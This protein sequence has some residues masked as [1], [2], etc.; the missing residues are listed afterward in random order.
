MQLLFKQWQIVFNLSIHISESNETF[1]SITVVQPVD[2][3]GGGGG[4]GYD[5][6][7]HKHIHWAHW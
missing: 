7:M 2:M 1:V 6:R 3:R 5:T 4:V